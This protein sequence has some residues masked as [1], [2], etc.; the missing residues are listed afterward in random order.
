VRAYLALM[1]T[2]MPRLRFDVQMPTALLDRPFPPWL[3][4]TLAENAVKHGVEPKIG[5]AQ[6]RVSAEATADGGLAVTVADD[7]VG[8]GGS[9]SGSGLGLANIRGRLQQMFGGQ[10]GLQL[11]ARPGGGVAATITL[12]PASA[13]DGSHGEPP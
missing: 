6:V 12:P 8:F 13:G 3:L 11:A 9:T 7:G 4:I 2:R 1:A 5:P 10:A